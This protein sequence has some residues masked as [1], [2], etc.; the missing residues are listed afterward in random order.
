MSASDAPAWV[1]LG[2]NVGPR[3]M[4]LAAGIARLE[5]TPGVVV[6]AR[7][8]WYETA[9][10]GG[11]AGQRPFWN[12]AV[13]LWTRLEPLALLERCL[14]I[15]A[16][17]GRV[18]DPGVCDGPRTLDLD[19]LLWDALCID[20]PRL[21]LPHPRLEQRAFVIEPL[22]ELAPVH[23][24]PSGLTAR[25]RLATFPP[26]LRGRRVEGRLHADSTAPGS[27]DA[28]RG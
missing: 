8:S 5:A 2:S 4:L 18:R 15:E 14:A 11:P 17:L 26:E 12:G 1:A 28:R 23:V 10:V 3:G 6:A 20:E 13:A 21:T 27:E 7:S 19:L 22:A 9:P 24:L 25:E 16:S